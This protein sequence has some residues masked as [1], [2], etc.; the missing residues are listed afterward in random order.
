VSFG[1]G[2]RK[3]KINQRGVWSPSVPLKEEI[4]QKGGASRSR[5]KKGGTGEKEF[6]AIEREGNPGTTANETSFFSKRKIFEK[7]KGDTGQRRVLKKEGT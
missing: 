7:E 5:L 4:P 6:K 2:R 1:T 3:K